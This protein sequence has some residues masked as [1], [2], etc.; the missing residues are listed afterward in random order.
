MVLD[1][2][3]RQDVRGAPGALEMVTLSLDRMA[4]GGIH[5]QV[6]GGFARYSTDA[7]WHVP[8]FEKM[9][10]DNAQLALVYTHAWSV[11]H[12]ARFRDVA[13]RTLGYLRREMQHPD[14]WLLHVA[15]RR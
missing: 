4:G 7:R 9:L 6:G 8:H 12:E 11:T 15:G 3:L 10:S 1:F 14:G 13:E 2:L 5:D